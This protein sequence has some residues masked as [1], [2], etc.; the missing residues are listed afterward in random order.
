MNWYSLIH[1]FFQNLSEKM[2]KGNY[3]NASAGKNNTVLFIP[4]N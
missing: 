1:R 4:I 2:M 3:R